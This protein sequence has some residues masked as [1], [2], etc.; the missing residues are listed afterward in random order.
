MVV[1]LLARGLDGCRKIKPMEATEKL[2][3]YNKML[4]VMFFITFITCVPPVAYYGW[5]R[6]NGSL[7]SE[8]EWQKIGGNH[9]P[10]WGEPQEIFMYLPGF[11]MLAYPT[12]TILFTIAMMLEMKGQRIVT[13]AKGVASAIIIFV[14]GYRLFFIFWTVD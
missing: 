10:W 9:G 11:A 13:F 4:K 6:A 3:I 12:T 5:A 2:K 7:P 14:V 8:A 1:G